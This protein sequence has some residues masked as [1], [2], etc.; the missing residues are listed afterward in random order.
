MTGCSVQGDHPQ[1][2]ER[3]VNPRSRM[4]R[5]TS[6]RSHQRVIEVSGPEDAEMTELF[7]ESQDI[8]DL[9]FNSEVEHIF[10]MSGLFAVDVSCLGSCCIPREHR[11][12][13]CDL[14]TRDI[15]GSSDSQTTIWDPVRVEWLYSA[16]KHCNPRLII[17]SVGSSTW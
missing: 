11:T 7:L 14:L 9:F 6:K 5:E 16:A 8:L 2:L 15:L 1:C 4:S 17:A 13:D 3:F 12:V 10:K